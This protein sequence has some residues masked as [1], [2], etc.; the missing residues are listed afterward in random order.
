VPLEP[1]ALRHQLGIRGAHGQPPDLGVAGAVALAS[2]GARQQ[3]AAEAE[4][5]HGNVGV[6]GPAEQVRL[7]HHERLRV[8]EG[9]ELRS[10]RDDQVVLTRVDLALVQIDPEHLA[11]RAVRVEPFGDQTG[12]RR[13][14]VLQDQRPH[15]TRG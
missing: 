15:R 3:L 11:H 9:G 5:Q 4:P 1:R 7:A 12:G 10:K 8:V 13:I 6:D 14:L 2:E